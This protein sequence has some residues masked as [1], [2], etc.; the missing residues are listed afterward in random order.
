MQ[1]FKK[2]KKKINCNIIQDLISFTLELHTLDTYSFTFAICRFTRAYIILWREN[3]SIHS[4]PLSHHSRIAY[5][6]LYNTVIIAGSLRSR[7]RSRFHQHF[8]PSFSLFPRH[9]AIRTFWSE[10]TV[11]VEKRRERDKKKKDGHVSIIMW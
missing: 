9:R 2:R 7:N 11:A 4:H 8:Y 1:W 3:H 10:N 6:T 5:H